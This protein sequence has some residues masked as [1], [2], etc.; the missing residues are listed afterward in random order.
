MES[1]CY[2]IHIEFYFY[3]DLRIIIF[4]VLKMNR[5]TVQEVSVSD[6]SEVAGSLPGTSTWETYL[7]G[8]RVE[9]NPLSLVRATG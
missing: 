3:R 2:I 4:K 8:I 5:F 9:W 6:Y 1:F 7:I